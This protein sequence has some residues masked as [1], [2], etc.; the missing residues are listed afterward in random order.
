[1][2][3]SRGPW[4]WRPR[5]G[6]E[7]PALLDAEG[8]TVCSFGADAQYYPTEGSPPEEEDARL[9]EKAPQLL[10]ALREAV[11]VIQN[12]DGCTGSPCFLVGTGLES[13]CVPCSSRALIREIDG[14]PSNR[15]EPDKVT[16]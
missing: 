4:K 14:E 2:T 9:I 16:P 1:M 15:A 10:E 3:R 11:N 5:R 7:L 8:Y 12:L 6:N 13:R